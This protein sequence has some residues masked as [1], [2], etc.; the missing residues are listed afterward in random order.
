LPALWQTVSWTFSRKKTQT[1]KTASSRLTLPWLIIAS[2][3]F[4]GVCTTRKLTQ[5]VNKLKIETSISLRMR[6]EE[7]EIQGKSN[8]GILREG[9]AGLPVAEICRKHGISNATYYQ[10]KS[11]TS[12]VL[13]RC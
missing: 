1:L 5:M 2:L 11:K 7:V 6:D 4:R 10:W 8:F 12:G 9:E 3:C 13:I